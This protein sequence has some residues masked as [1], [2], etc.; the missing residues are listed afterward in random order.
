MGK[1]GYTYIISNQR[2]TTLYIGVTEDLY[3]RIYKHKTN[4]FPKSFSARY[5]LDKLVY[6][7]S[8]GSIEAAID[9]EKYLKGKTRKFKEDLINKLNQIG[10]IH[11]TK[12]RSGKSAF[13]L[14]PKT[15]F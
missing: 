3:S 7:K 13:I 1:G 10:M 4:A 15:S 11:L 2:N 9:Y 14:P 5:N 8:F 12:S 6:F